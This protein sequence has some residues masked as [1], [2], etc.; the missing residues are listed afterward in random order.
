M[1]R[2]WRALLAIATLALL[3]TGLLSTGAQPTRATAA[4]APFQLPASLDLHDGTIQDFAGTYYAYG[5]MYGCGYQWYVS[6]TAWCG[7]GVSTAP[8]LTGPWS[9]PTLLFPANS[10]DPWTGQTWQTECGS[11]G[12]G[13]FNPRMI[14]RS[15]WGANDGVYVLWFNSPLDWSTNHA[16]AYN[17]LGCN[18][19]AG[20]CGP[21]AGAPHGSYT[22]P[23]L[24]YCTGNG[25]FGVIQSGTAGQAPALICSQPGAASLSMEQLNW[26]GVGGQSGAGA[27]NIA[28]L[29]TVEGPGGYYDTASGRYV[30]TYAEP[31]CGYCSGTAT[32]YATAT[33]MLGPYTAPS[34]VAVAN[35]Q[36]TAR[37]LITANSC[38]G[39]PRTVAVVDG[40]AWQGIDLWTGSRNETTAGVLYTP[41]TF[42][43]PSNTAGDGQIWQPFTFTC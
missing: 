34:N 14:Q 17:A 15:G 2:P 21:T 12:Q 32:G 10:T 25:D 5:T 29:G 11:T 33:A 9:T 43:N 16:N 40:Q 37:A 22:K 36:P 39:Q 30:I 3:I 4:P 24:S 42:T 27:N 23:S 7:F 38:G 1:R 19:P 18:G 8:S 35:N 28:G 20:P 31:D 6:N 26:W 41:L 13:C